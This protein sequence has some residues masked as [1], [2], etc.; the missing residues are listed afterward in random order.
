MSKVHHSSLQFGLFVPAGFAQAHLACYSGAL[1][2]ALLFGAMPVS[3]AFSAD[4]AS[5][6]D[7]PMQPIAK[8]KP[9][10]S[11]E[12]AGET[13]M[14]LPLVPVASSRESRERGLDRTGPEFPGAAASGGQSGA[15]SVEAL[16]D[17]TLND[18]GDAAA[19]LGVTTNSILR[20]ESR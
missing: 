12:A 2:L 5:P 1:V 4:A 8:P 15:T 11:G 14:P 18:I 7:A 13:L 19:N 17:R 16:V 6:L 9:K 20:P 10:V 3:G